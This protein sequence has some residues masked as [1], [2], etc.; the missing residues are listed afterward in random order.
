MTH[1]PSTRSI[2]GDRRGTPVRDVRS[3]EQAQETA[4]PD[5]GHGAKR[6]LDG[7]IDAAQ[8]SER[9]EAIDPIELVINAWS[10]H[11]IAPSGSC[12]GVGVRG[13]W[14]EG[15][16]LARRRCIGRVSV[17]ASDHVFVRWSVSNSAQACHKLGA[18]SIGQFEGRDAGAPAVVVAAP[19]STRATRQ[20]SVSRAEIRGRLAGF[21]DPDMI[22]LHLCGSQIQAAIRKSR[23]KEAGRHLTRALGSA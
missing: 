12:P 7:C 16:A 5:A 20:S 11:R 15:G 18:N 6:N 1:L 14:V 23:H 13:C 2:Y 22:A 21:L 9:R 3:T 19:V 4:I 10:T 17:R 8:R